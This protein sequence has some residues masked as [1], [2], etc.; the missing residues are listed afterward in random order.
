[1]VGTQN[2]VFELQ[3]MA[4]GAPESALRVTGRGPPRCSGPWLEPPPSRCASVTAAFLELGVMSWLKHLLM[5][6]GL[7]ACAPFVDQSLNKK[8]T[9]GNVP[10]R[11]IPS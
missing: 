3:H 6:H 7:G 8:E 9:G 10:R 4:Q 5:I 1:M 2:A 11:S